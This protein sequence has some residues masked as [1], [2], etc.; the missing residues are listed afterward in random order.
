MSGTT[1]GAAI[2]AWHNR[3]SFAWTV[4]TTLVMAAGVAITEWKDNTDRILK[5]ETEV[6]YVHKQRKEDLEAARQQRDEDRQYLIRIETK[7]DGLI[8]EKRGGHGNFSG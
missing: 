1:P 6:S 2:D 8:K 4:I 7:L 3:A 5:L